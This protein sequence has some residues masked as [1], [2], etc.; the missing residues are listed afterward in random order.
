MRLD[1]ISGVNVPSYYMY[2][3]PLASVGPCA[4]FQAVSRTI[5]LLP[6][7]PSVTSRRD[8]CICSIP[9]YSI[10]GDAK[11]LLAVYLTG[12]RQSACIVTASVRV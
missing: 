6:N 4:R 3:S 2:F 5:T 7:A 11:R 8:T 9:T 1:E 12:F 10:H